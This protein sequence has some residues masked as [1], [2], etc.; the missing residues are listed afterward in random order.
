MMWEIYPPGLN[1]LLTRVTREYA[2]PAEIYITENGIPVPDGIDA[3]G[4]VRDER[5]VRYLQQH[6]ARVHQAIG[7]GITIRGYF[8]WSLL[9]NFEWAQGYHLRFGVAYVDFA[10]LVRTIKDSGLWY[11][12]VVRANGLVAAAA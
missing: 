10:T 1:E 6:I 7:A 5:R 2:V 12:R 4:R 8:V 3:D 11:S 9:D